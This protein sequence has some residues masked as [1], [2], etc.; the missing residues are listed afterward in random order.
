VK[1]LRLG[2][3]CVDHARMFFN[4]PDYDLGSAH[5]PSFAL[6]PEGA[7]YDDLKRDYAAMSAMIFG[8]PPRFDAIVQSV[9]A[10]EQLVNG[11]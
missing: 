10:V 11:G 2:A 6:T 5:P 4:R 7:M 9:A 8:E 3:D 1:D